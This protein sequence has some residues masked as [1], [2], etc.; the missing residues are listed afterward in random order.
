MDI[1][2]KKAVLFRLH[3]VPGTKK[4]L[5]IGSPENLSIVNETYFTMRMQ[6]S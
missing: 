6:I 4:V 3:L 1:F 5:K 2:V